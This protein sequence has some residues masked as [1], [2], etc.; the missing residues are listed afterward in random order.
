MS[1]RF[2]QGDLVEVDHQYFSRFEFSA[3][4]DGKADEHGCGDKMRQA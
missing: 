4:I 3:A 1:H 2:R